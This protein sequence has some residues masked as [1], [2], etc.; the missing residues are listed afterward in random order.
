M[1]VIEV[2]N[3]SMHYGPVKAVDAV[4]F[5]AERG[6]VLGLLG[7]NGAGK[8]TTMN[9]IAGHLVPGV[10]TVVVGGH[11]VVEEPVEVRKLIGYLPEKEPLYPEMEVAEFV[12][13][14]GE[15]RG[16]A[17][18]RLRKRIEWVLDACSLRPVYRKLLSDLSRGY[19]QRVGLAQ[20]LI[21]DPAVL[22]LDELT[23]GLDPLQTSEIRKLVKNLAKGN[24]GPGKCIVFSTHVMQEAEAVSDR[25]VIINH[26]RIVAEG[27]PDEIRMQAAASHVTLITVEGAP[28]DMEKTLKG[29]PGV[30]E[31]ELAGREGGL[32]SCRIKSSNAGELW[33]ELAKT[34]KSK[35]WLVKELTPS[36]PSLEDAFLALT[37]GGKQTAAPASSPE[38]RRP[39]DE[40]KEKPSPASGQGG[41][42]SPWQKKIARMAQEPPGPDTDSGGEEVEK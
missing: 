36:M 22:I 14:V 15:A 24:G 29:L 38:K 4:S 2:R 35:G 34:I 6:E 1:T 13:F 16:L 21:H 26:G 28:E 32:V 18:E 25:I 7:P 39:P 5:S 3:V 30:I 37:R 41:G 33:Q 8:T 20:A 10:G 12:K 17:G 40:V 27:K 42:L 31:V 19:R 23:S 11:D 9:V